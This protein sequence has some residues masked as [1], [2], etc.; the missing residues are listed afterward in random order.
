MKSPKKRRAN[1]AGP[2]A[3]QAVGPA[4]GPGRPTPPG[5]AGPHGEARPS[6]LSLGGLLR[7]A[8]RR[9]LLTLTVGAVLGA[10]A[11]FASWYLL[12]PRYTATA[13]LRVSAT[14]PQVLPERAAERSGGSASEYKKTQA[15]LVKSRP[16]L[17]AALKGDKVRALATVQEQPDA[18]AWLEKEL[19]VAYVDHTELLRISLAGLHAA[20][21]TVLVNAVKDAYLQEV[22]TAERNGLL[23]QLDEVEKIY[24]A[25]EEKVRSQREL[26]RKLAETL[27]TSDSQALT[28]KQRIA[29]EEYATLKKE[30]TQ[31]EL[32]I[33]AARATLEVQRASAGLLAKGQ[34]IPDAL[35]DRQ[36]EAAPAVQQQLAEVQRVEQDLRT[37][38]GVYVEGTPVLQRLQ[39]SLEQ[40]KEKLLAVRKGQREVALK[41]LRDQTHIQALEQAAATETQLRVLEK[42]LEGLAPEVARLDREAEKIGTKSF[43]L[44][45]K[46]AEVEEAE[47]LI[48]RLRMEKQRL[49]VEAQSTKRRVRLLAAA[50]VPTTARGDTQ[51][52]ALLGAAGFFLGAFGVAYREFRGRRIHTTDDVATGLGV[53]VV[54]M[55]PAL[56]HRL[57]QQ[58]QPDAPVGDKQAYWENLLAESVAGIRTV[59]LCDERAS[60]SRALMVTSANKG[61]GKTTLAGLLATSIA[62]AGHRA[63]LIDADLR[64]PTLH[65]ALG[66]PPRP[67]LAEVL[68][69]EAELAGAIRPGAAEGLFVLTAGRYAGHAEQPLTRQQIRKVFEKAREEFDYLIVD[70]PPVLPVHDALLFGK[71]VDAVLLTIRPG[72]SRAPAVD[73]AL[74]RLRTL[75]ISVFGAVVNGVR[76]RDP[77][78]EYLY[79]PRAAEPY[80][81]TGGPADE[82]LPA[83]VDEQAE[84]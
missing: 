56:P 50:E 7:A 19:K 33:R 42:Q 31:L 39:K 6:G 79:L 4:A 64:S 40:E 2:G 68:R 36:A 66:L 67:G 69:E 46:R 82:P 63:L 38:R 81:E 52:A 76:T 47:A 35:V 21:V 1:A 27:K 34:P 9:W 32:Q 11:A 58:A 73:A 43:E 77:D 8:R 84:P 61:E 24:V 49:E 26:L 14:D 57:L 45:L 20:D 15:A 78:S 74:A 59:L 12:P 10:A 48:K 62:R 71:H 65:R 54:G 75:S 83:A 70:S 41:Q 25:S 3:D 55:L 30:T 29:L 37:A 23:A 72:V 22:V 17:Q 44:E 80:G 28:L 51:T 18:L 16:V 60:K 53:R 5:S 13:L